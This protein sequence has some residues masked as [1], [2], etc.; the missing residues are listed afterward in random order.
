MPTY[1]YTCLGCD[2]DIVRIAKIDQRDE[3]VCECGEK[4]LRK[5]DRPGMVWAPT[6]GGYR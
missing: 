6:A 2:K 1:T 5:I 3:Q 4:L